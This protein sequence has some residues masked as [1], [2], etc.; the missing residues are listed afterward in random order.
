MRREQILG[1]VVIGGGLLLLLRSAAHASS[2]PGPD[3]TPYLTTTPDGQSWYVTP[4]PDG[5]YYTPV[6][7]TGSHVLPGATT[8]PDG[9]SWEGDFCLRAE[10]HATP[11]TAEQIAAA[12][13]AAA[14]RRADRIRAEQEAIQDRLG[15]SAAQREVYQREAA[16]GSP[17]NRTARLQRLGTV[18]ALVPLPS[19]RHSPT[20]VSAWSDSVL[21]IVAAG[22]ASWDALSGWE[23]AELMRDYL[24][25]DRETIAALWG[26][27]PI[28]GYAN[29]PI[30]FNAFP[31][32]WTPP[33]RLTIPAFAAP[34]R[35]ASGSSR[36]LL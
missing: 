26:L 29:T 12:E 10:A 36:L 11:P 19:P 4:T 17:P 7:P 2:L 21:G 23:R 1:A 24:S 5:D 18:N 32:F 27:N 13:A 28:F 14:Q 9:R 3:Y 34:V 30:A 22:L 6:C 33:A 31:A 25:L 35:L 15:M 8:G 16:K 20:S